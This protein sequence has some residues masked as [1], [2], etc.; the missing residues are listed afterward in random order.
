MTVQISN[1]WGI[2]QKLY[3]WLYSKYYVRKTY[4]A[5]S[6]SGIDTAGSFLYN[7]RSGEYCTAAIFFDWT[8]DGKID[9]AALSGQVIR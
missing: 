7:Y 6:K 8:N 4:T 1:D 2:A 5:T 3:N 9:H